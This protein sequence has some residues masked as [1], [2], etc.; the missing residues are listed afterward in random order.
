M[1]N[2]GDQ[3]VRLFFNKI[4]RFYPNGLHPVPQSIEFNIPGG[5]LDAKG[6]KFYSFCILLNR[7]PAFPRG[8][9]KIKKR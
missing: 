9:K 6:V 5:G 7:Q 1:L 2:V 3:K 8:L 4:F